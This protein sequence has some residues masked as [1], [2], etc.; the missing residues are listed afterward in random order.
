V[1]TVAGLDPAPLDAEGSVCTGVREALAQA[2]DPFVA[3]AV[4]PAELSIIVLGATVTRDPLVG[5]HE[6]EAA[7]RAA[8]LAAFGYE[9][10]ELGQDVALGDLIAA[11]HTVPSVLS[12]TVTAL[13]L[14][15]ATASASDV[16]RKLP[17][18]LSQPVAQVT[19]VSG[20]DSGLAPAGV[21]YLTDAVADTLILNESAP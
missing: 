4:L 2:A 17:T 12:F 18:L 1:V 9:P 11:A 13:A 20:P 5:W 15:S 8:L 16:A 21:A 6:T 14:V 10:R 3:F 19:A 7:V